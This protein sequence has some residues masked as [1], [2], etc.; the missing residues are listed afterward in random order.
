[1]KP[2]KNVIAALAEI[3]DHNSD[4]ICGLRTPFLWR[5]STVDLARRARIADR[6][7][8]APAHLA[9]WLIR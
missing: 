4:A 7:R 2:K 9:D 1:M 8:A 5:R 3:I 6:R